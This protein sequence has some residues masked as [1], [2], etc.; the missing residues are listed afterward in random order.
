MLGPGHIE[1]LQ[2][3][4]ITILVTISIT[5]VVVVTRISRLSNFICLHLVVKYV[6]WLE[7]NKKAQSRNIKTNVMVNDK[8]IGLTDYKKDQIRIAE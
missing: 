6:L 2:N 7:H 5:S 8:Y 1:T 4:V 3:E